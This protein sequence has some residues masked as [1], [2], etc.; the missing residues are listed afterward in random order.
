MELRPAML[1]ALGSFDL[2]VDEAIAQLAQEPPLSVAN[3]HSRIGVLRSLPMKQGGLGIM[4]F[5]SFTAEAFQLKS[6]SIAMEYASSYCPWLREV[7][8]SPLVWPEIVIGT[9]DNLSDD[10]EIKDRAED[11]AAERPSNAKR[12]HQCYEIMAHAL[13]QA[14]MDTG[15]LALA[16]T[17][18]SQSDKGTGRLFLWGG[19]N[20][21][22][23]YVP[24]PSDY[25]LALR[26]RI[27]LPPIRVLAL[28]GEQVRCTCGTNYVA[29][30]LDPF[31]ALSCRY[32]AGFWKIRHDNLVAYLVDLI[33]HT[34]ADATVHREVQL[35]IANPDGTPGGGFII[36]DIVIRMDHRVYVIDVSICDASAAS[37]RL[38]AARFND[39]AAL[40]KEGKKRNKYARALVAF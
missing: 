26:H 22:R 30:H 14:L 29:I 5:C 15:E 12:V 33:N 16:A 23:L 9:L 32:N 10:L 19:G 40:R 27:L 21:L 34:M 36:A 4:R 37:V 24:S 38:Q 13:W 25:R 1:T 20:D 17:F 8:R 3:F 11:A 7:A 35:V 6:R 39:F 18:R 31:H 2:A 28:E